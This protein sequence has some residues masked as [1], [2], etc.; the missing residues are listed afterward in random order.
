MYFLLSMVGQNNLCSLGEKIFFFSFASD[1]VRVCVILLGT[2]R[3]G[4]QVLF[5]VPFK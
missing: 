5:F 4:D 3:H 1:Y 2:A